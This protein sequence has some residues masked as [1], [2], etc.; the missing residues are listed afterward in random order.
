MIKP[1][2]VVLV[3]D[4]TYF[5]K[6]R[7]AT[8]LDGVMVFV[9][10]LTGQVLWAKFIKSETNSHYQEGLNYLESRGFEILGVVSDGRRGL[11][12]I[13]NKYPYQVCQF[14][15]QKGVSTLLTRNPKNP[16]GKE[17]KQFNDTFIKEKWTYSNFM[18][19]IEIYL[20]T[21]KDY[22]NE[23]SE[24]DSKQY[25]HK[26]LRK[27]L[28]KYNLNHKYMFTFQADLELKIPNTT[29]KID[30]GVFSPMKKLL[31]NHS[32]T[33]KLRRQN[34]IIEFLNSRGK[35]IT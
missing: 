4:T 7:E 19:Q 24:I 31:N 32:G 22:L 20:K 12:R 28:N 16:A 5:G 2:K 1:K 23:M 21:H 25:K 35:S 18:T 13:F 9:D 34:L 3:V 33:T 6:R 11:T 10:V 15:I 26:R 27:A 17:L 8:E 14:H 29:N 30:G